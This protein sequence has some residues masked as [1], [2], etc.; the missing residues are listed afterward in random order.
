M[1]QFPSLDAEHHEAT[2]DGIQLAG[3][4]LA[5][6]RHP[7]RNEDSF[8]ADPGLQMIAVFDG[9]GGRPGSEAASQEAARSIQE[10]AAQ[11]SEVL[12]PSDAEALLR[13]T[14]LNAHQ[15]VH[16]LGKGGIGTT[17][18]VAKVFRDESGNPY[19][20]IANVADSRVY[21]FRAGELEFLSYDKG[22][23]YREASS[24]TV[25]DQQRLADVADRSQ[26]AGFTI[27]GK[28]GFEYRNIINS[29]LGQDGEEPT[30]TT[31]SEP[32][33]PGDQILVT[34]DGVHDNL[35]HDEIAEILELTE[36]A[37]AA[38]EALT[39]LARERSRDNH[40]RS[41]PDDITAAALFY[42]PAA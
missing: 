11:F 13:A 12:R 36:G 8:I 5:S 9:V 32:L 6:D 42:D 2:N 34:S 10:E 38:V 17:A 20:G 35:T 23:E 28:I 39:L 26:L 18:A 31:H 14:L 16:D 37:E 7:D 27:S 15:D 21:R 40:L 33:L 22:R 1:I 3:A 25:F 30:V 19:V 24:K 41:K 29:M 4:S